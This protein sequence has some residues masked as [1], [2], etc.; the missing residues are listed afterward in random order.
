MLL[1]YVLFL[2][3]DILCFLDRSFFFEVFGENTL[4]KSYTFICGDVISFRV[5]S[6]CAS[7]QLIFS[8]YKKY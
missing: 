3:G 8:Y 7:K 1:K 5:E 2:V 6:D 4:S